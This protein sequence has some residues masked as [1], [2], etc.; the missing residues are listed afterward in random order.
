MKMKLDYYKSDKGIYVASHHISYLNRRDELDKHRPVK[1]NEKLPQKTHH[2]SWLF[3]EGETELKS[4]SIETTGERCNYRWELRDSTPELVKK[5]LPKVIT[6][7]DSDEYYDDD[8]GYCIGGKCE[9]SEY[10]N[11]YTRT[12]DTNP[13][14]FKDQDIEITLLGD[15]ESNWVKSPVD[16]KYSVWRSSYKHEGDT[17]LD[18]SDIASFSELS[19][20]MTPDLL[21][22]NQPCSL[23]SEQ[24]YKIVRK[25]VSDN[26]D[27]KWA[28]IT[29]DYDFCFTVKKKIAIKPYVRVNEQTKRNGRSYR[30]PRLSTTKVTHK[31][32]Q[33]FE[34]THK[35]ANYHGYTAIAGFNGDNLQDLIDNIEQFLNELMD[36]INAPLSECNHC[37]GSGHILDDDFDKNKR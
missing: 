10:Q 6:Q 30:K 24:T 15:I 20:I 31:E 26:I 36:H 1:I 28:R 8:D 7:E 34:M 14:Y 11:F 32:Q 4:L 35:R 12:Y 17:S 29:S 25:Y 5:T 3:V 22:H 37:N 27:P 33:I 19:K 23:T 9:H 2:V 21:L 13:D 16:A 18:I